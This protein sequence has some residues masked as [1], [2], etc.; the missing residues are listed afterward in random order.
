MPKFYKIR[1]MDLPTVVFNGENYIEF[2]RVGSDRWELDTKDPVF[3]PILKK[4]GFPIYDEE[5]PPEAPELISDALQE[6]QAAN[7][8]MVLPTAGRAKIPIVPK[9]AK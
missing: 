5:N 1:G 7:T 8:E 6:K 9:A 3:I 2:V 4:M